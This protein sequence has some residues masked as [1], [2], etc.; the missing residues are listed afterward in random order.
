VGLKKPWVGVML[1]CGCVFLSTQYD[2]PFSAH[3]LTIPLILYQS[4]SLFISLKKRSEND[5][6]RFY[7]STSGSV[8]KKT[9]LTMVGLLGLISSVVG[10]M[11][12]DESEIYCIVSGL[13]SFLLFLDGVVSRPSSFIQ[14]TE[15]ELEYW[16]DSEPLESKVSIKFNSYEVI[17]VGLLLKYDFEEVLIAENWD[18]SKSEEKGVKAFI[19][20]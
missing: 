14:K 11:F 5:D 7:V 12:L 19:D 9:S 20:S 13:Y 16:S 8:G 15:S 6:G 18:L 2:L 3:Y 1:L 4:F 17:D 10:L